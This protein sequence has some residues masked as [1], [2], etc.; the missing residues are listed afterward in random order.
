MIKHENEYG[1]T[2]YQNELIRTDVSKTNSLRKTKTEI[3]LV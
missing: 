2:G 3:Q 1:L